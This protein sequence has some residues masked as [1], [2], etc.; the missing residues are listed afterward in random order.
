MLP[1]R[2]SSPYVHFRKNRFDS[3]P[4][5]TRQ[6]EPV[7]NLSLSPL[8][9]HVSIAGR[10]FSRVDDVNLSTSITTALNV[11][12]TALGA[13]WIDSLAIETGPTAGNLDADT[14]FSG[15]RELVCNAPHTE[16]E[17]LAH[18][19]LL[20]Q[21]GD[22][23]R[24]A[25]A[26]GGVVYYFN[27]RTRE[28][29]WN[30]PQGIVRLKVVSQVGKESNGQGGDDGEQRLCSISELDTGV[31]QTTS[32]L[33]YSEIRK[34]SCDAS[35]ITEVGGM[36]EVGVEYVGHITAKKTPYNGGLLAN[37]LLSSKE[38][39]S[40]PLAHE[41]LIHDEHKLLD[42]LSLD[43]QYPINKL[44]FE[45]DLQESTINCSSDREGKSKVVTAYVGS[46]S[47][48]DDAA[49]WMEAFPDTALNVGQDIYKDGLD[50]N[51]AD[52]G[53][54][55]C[56]ESPYPQTHE[57]GGNGRF[58]V[59]HS[60]ISFPN[61][62]S[63]VQRVDPIGD[64][65]SI[66]SSKLFKIYLQHTCTRT[67]VQHTRISYHL[68]LGMGE[69]IPNSGSGLT[70]K[71]NYKYMDKMG[72]EVGDETELLTALFCPYCGA[73]LDPHLLASH[74]TVCHYSSNACMQKLV[75]LALLPRE[76]TVINSTV[77]EPPNEVEKL[78]YAFSVAT[79]LATS[80]LLITP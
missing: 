43:A 64:L 5:V 78:F 77:N 51:K 6:I 73:C 36:D 39:L 13:G 12:G 46:A 15:L 61:I 17:Q 29:Q 23:W 26:E 72:I 49:M 74:L 50:D 32:P 4:V 79:L 28:S 48:G 57:T 70:A 60:I 69:A 63:Q 22:E 75:E 34:K 66:P 24:Q 18:K 1:H 11:A 10:E 20:V 38:K 14:L 40:L 59:N 45:P 16:Q 76:I 31:H 67:E 25:T 68:T 52:V 47:F 2:A 58:A 8:P 27:R 53:G 62:Q 71:A 19:Q 37:P 80:S 54:G 3:S 42:D 55:D 21:L 65:N 33:E 44:S 35:A 41:R 7:I 9:Y 30:L 56:A